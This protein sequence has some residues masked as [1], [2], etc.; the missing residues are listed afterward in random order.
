MSSQKEFKTVTLIAVV[1]N[2][3]SVFI[4]DNEHDDWPMGTAYINL[5]TLD[6][7][8]TGG[9]IM[10]GDG[11]HEFVSLLASN[12]FFRYTGLDPDCSHTVHFFGIVGGCAQGVD[13]D[14]KARMVVE[15][16]G[17][18][19]EML[20]HYNEGESELSIPAVLTGAVDRWYEPDDTA[21][22]AFDLKATATLISF[23][24][25]RSIDWILQHLREEPTEGG[26]APTA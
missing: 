2:D 7:K 14:N 15:E 22:Q 20:F 12:E 23:N 26:N 25:S 8:P 1:A 5:S 19:V 6:G 21:V 9:I 13:P 11:Y 10:E 16:D 4:V 18:R 3:D 24:K 17:L